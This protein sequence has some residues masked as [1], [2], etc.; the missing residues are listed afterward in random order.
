MTEQPLS[1]DMAEVLESMRRTL[2]AKAKKEATTPETLQSAPK[3]QAKIVQLPLW[4]E[5]T[6]GTPNSFLRGA[7]FAAIQGKE[8]QGL[9]RQVL[10]SQKGSTIRFT[11]I[12]LDQSDLDV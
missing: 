10:A 2:E 4:P 12:Q 1:R 9:Q 11:G 6:R 8:R 7:L 5:P 3:P